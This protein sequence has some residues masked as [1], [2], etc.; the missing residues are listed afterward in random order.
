MGLF[1]GGLL[2]FVV[3]FCFGFGSERDVW[4]GI[5]GTAWRWGCI[6]GVGLMGRERD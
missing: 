6:F 1:W 2:R 5:W 4:L 3:W